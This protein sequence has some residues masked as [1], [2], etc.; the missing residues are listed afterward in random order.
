MLAAESRHPG[1][2]NADRLGYQVGVLDYVTSSLFESPAQTLV[3]TVNTVGVMGKGIANDFRRLY[4]DMFE[5]YRAFCAQGKF[6][7]GQLYLYRTPHKWV[8]NFPTK[9]HWRNPSRLEW[10]EA[11]LQKFLETYSQYGIT[12]VAFPQLGTG[13]GGLGWADVQPVMERYLKQVRI[14]V[15]IHVRPHDPEFVPEHLSRAGVPALS[16]ELQTA[17]DEVTFETFVSDL[18][19]VLHAQLRIPE[20][21]HELPVLEFQSPSGSTTVVPIERV[22][23]LWQSLKLTGALELANIPAAIR[24]SSPSFESKLSALDYIKPMTFGREERPGFRYAPP[25]LRVPPGAIDVESE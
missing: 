5:R 15:Y 6:S 2:V 16:R 24:Q 19:R 3:N 11:G 1:F 14:P 7:V 10:I 18:V 4:P 20:S 13:N 17:R 22:L 23:D 21:P 9:M 25:S 8:L 12:S